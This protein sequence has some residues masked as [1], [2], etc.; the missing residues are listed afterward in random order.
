MHTRGSARAMPAEPG[1]CSWDLILPVATRRWMHG[2]ACPAWD[3]VLAEGTGSPRRRG[4]PQVHATTTRPKIT[5]TADGDGVVSHAGSRLLADIAQVTG[6]DT[7]FDAIRR[8]RAAAPL[9]ARPGPG[10]DGSGG[11]AGRRR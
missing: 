5:V 2:S 3:S 8:R 10:A 9:G 1:G 4:T 6:L 11:D 7:G